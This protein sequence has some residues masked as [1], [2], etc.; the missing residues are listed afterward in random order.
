MVSLQPR[1]KVLKRSKRS[2]HFRL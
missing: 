1:E 2:F